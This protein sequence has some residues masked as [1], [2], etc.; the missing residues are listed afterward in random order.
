MT[1]LKAIFAF[2]GE[3]LGKLIPELIKE[4]KKP[5]EV[6]PVGGDSET[7]D[8]LDDSIRDSMDL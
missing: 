6:K 5:K 3:L 2:L 7:H 8:A 1:I 4:G